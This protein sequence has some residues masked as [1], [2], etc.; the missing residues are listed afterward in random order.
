MAGTAAD[1]ARLRAYAIELRDLLR[2]GKAE[3]LYREV[4]PSVSDD[5]GFYQIA[6]SPG[7]D[8]ALAH[9]ERHWIPEW[10]TDFEADDIRLRKWSG[11]R[12][13]EVSQV[14]PDGRVKPL[15]YQRGSY[16]RIFVGE[17]GGELRVV[18]I[19]F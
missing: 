16:L 17:V 12:I 14:R 2:S 15:L 19:T 4:Q 13:W 1:S 7:R 18:R 6:Y 3:A 5:R 8:S 11:G 10:R 9:I